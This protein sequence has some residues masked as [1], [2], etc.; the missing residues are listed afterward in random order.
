[1]CV[2]NR[3]FSP[4]TIG[5]S[6]HLRNFLFKSL[7]TGWV[8]VPPPTL[9]K[10]S[11]NLESSHHPLS[12]SSRTPSRRTDGGTD[13]RGLSDTPS[14]TSYCVGVT[15]HQPG[16]IVKRD[17]PH[18]CSIRTFKTHGGGVHRNSPSWF[19]R[20]GERR[21][22]DRSDPRCTT[23][24]DLVGRTGCS[25]SGYNPCR[26]FSVSSLVWRLFNPSSLRCGRGHKGDVSLCDGRTDSVSI[27][28]TE[29]ISSV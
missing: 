28:P 16:R 2:Y 7:F 29:T 21:K 14:Y 5:V 9:I 15:A 19:G 3:C 11:R 27:K 20:G 12:L 17:D 26:P 25:S 10:G 4:L 6:V 24:F 23:P 1:M 13:E 18:R 8:V 22:D